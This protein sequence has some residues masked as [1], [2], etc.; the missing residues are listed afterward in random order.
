MTLKTDTV[1]E[2]YDMVAERYDTVSYRGRRGERRPT[3]P[4]IGLERSL[5]S[6]FV[7]FYI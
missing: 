4:A 5:L 2:R 6:F 3:I 1:A 7:S